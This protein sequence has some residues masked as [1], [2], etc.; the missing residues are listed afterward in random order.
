MAILQISELNYTGTLEKFKTSTKY[1]IQNWKKKKKNKSPFDDNLKHQT[2]FYAAQ[3]GNY[4]VT[5][6]MIETYDADPNVTHFSEKVAYRYP[7]SRCIYYG[8][9]TRGGGN[10]RDTAIYLLDN[11]AIPHINNNEPLKACY[12]ALIGML[13]G[14][15]NSVSSRTI[16]QGH[17]KVAIRLLKEPSVMETVFAL[18]QEEYY[19]L[20]P[21]IKDIFIF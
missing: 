17:D 21:K 14:V 5:K 13:A 7:L 2:L 18:N 3:D 15:K 9:E 12:H 8:Y 11:G 10:F 20:F 16:E 1:Y 19:F 4:E 6:Y